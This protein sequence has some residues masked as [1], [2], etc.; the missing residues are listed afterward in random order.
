[1]PEVET[2]VPQEYLRPRQTPI[3]A[4]TKPRQAIPQ[5]MGDKAAP[6]GKKKEMCIYLFFH[7]LFKKEKEKEKEKKR[8]QKKQRKRKRKGKKG[9]NKREREKR[10]KE[11]E[12]RK[13]KREIER[14][15][16][17]R[18]REKKHQIL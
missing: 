16:K 8:K 4:P 18:E 2:I 14:K 15:E 3:D 12:K 6:G 17:E 13:G 9:K 5:P 7:S 10:E 1:M 11:K